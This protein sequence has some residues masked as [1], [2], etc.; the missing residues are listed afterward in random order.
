MDDY[1]ETSE[2]IPVINS[3]IERAWTRLESVLPALPENTDYTVL[4]RLLLKTVL[5]TGL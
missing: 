5:Q 2:P 3:F 4:D 1:S